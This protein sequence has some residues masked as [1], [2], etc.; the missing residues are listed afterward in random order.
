MLT[1]FTEESVTRTNVY[2]QLKTVMQILQQFFL[3]SPS[4]KCDLEKIHQQVSQII[5]EHL[6]LPKPVT[7]PE[8]SI[9]SRTR[10]KLRARSKT[11]P[12]SRQ[13]NES[14]LPRLQNKLKETELLWQIQMQKL[15]QLQTILALKIEEDIQEQWKCH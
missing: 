9:K 3:H 8:S 11:R 15:T 14:V 5:C 10:E 12:M 13:K 4:A 6:K 2:V 1:A 7:A